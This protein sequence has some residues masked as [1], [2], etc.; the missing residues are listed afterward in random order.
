MK[1]RTQIGELERY[2]GRTM[3]GE[4]RRK[5]G[6]SLGWHRGWLWTELGHVIYQI[7]QYRRM[8]KY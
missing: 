2:S 6:K 8:D 5:K 3:D 7:T 1:R 4:V